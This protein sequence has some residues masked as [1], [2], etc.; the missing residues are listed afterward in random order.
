[1][2]WNDCKDTKFHIFDTETLEHV[3][4]N[5]PNRLFYT[6][7]YEDDDHQTL[8]AR[9]YKDKIVSISQKLSKKFEK[10]R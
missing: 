10:I 3:P 4:V 8:D 2:F 5:N 1:M 9:E 6:I 7:Y